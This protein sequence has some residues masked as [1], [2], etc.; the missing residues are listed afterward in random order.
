[1]TTTAT[2]ELLFGSGITA[3]VFS[4]PGGGFAQ[5]VITSPDGDIV[6]DQIALLPGPYSATASLSSGAWLMQIAAFRPA[7][8]EPGPPALCIFLTTTNTAVLAWPSPSTGFT[9]QQNSI[10]G[11]TNWISATSTVTVI[12][13]ENQVT[14]SP[15]SGNQF[16]RSHIRNT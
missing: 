6:E 11:T 12:G 3:A 10:L 8:P 14:I 4:A 5:R 13:T 2:N 16:Y 15:P 9:L 7:P 1:V